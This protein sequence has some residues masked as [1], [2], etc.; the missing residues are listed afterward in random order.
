[1]AKIVGVVT[2]CKVCPNRSYY[3]GGRYECSKVNQVLAPE[4]ALPSWCPLAEH[5]SVE[6]GRAQVAIA[7]GRAVL[8]VLK[9]ELASCGASDRVME[10]VSIALKQF[11][12]VPA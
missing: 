7:E 10:L 6:I 5:P 9:S 2:S 12:R 11:P 4:I 8:D 1:M 3:S